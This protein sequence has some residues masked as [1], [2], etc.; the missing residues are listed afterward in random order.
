MCCCDGKDIHTMTVSE[1][2]AVP[3]VDLSVPLLVETGW[4]G[5]W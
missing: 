2:G 4:A 3:A 1:A 5:N